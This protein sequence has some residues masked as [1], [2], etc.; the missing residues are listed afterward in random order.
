MTEAQEKKIRAWMGYIGETDK[1]LIEECIQD[2]RDDADMLDYFI[3]RA[4][5]LPANRG[6]ANQR[7]D[8]KF[9]PPFNVDKARQETVDNE[10]EKIRQV[11][12]CRSSKKV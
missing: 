3:T 5:E 8:Y 9:M 4:Q 12:P 11:I 6:K 7:P 2:C 1:A 10:M